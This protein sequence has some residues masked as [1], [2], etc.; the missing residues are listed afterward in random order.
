MRGH[1]TKFGRK[2]DKVLPH[3]SRTE[4]TRRPPG[5]AP[6]RRA[7]AS[8]STPATMNDPNHTCTQRGDHDHQPPQLSPGGDGHAEDTDGDDR[9]LKPVRVPHSNLLRI[10]HSRN[11]R[12]CYGAQRH[13]IPVIRPHIENRRSEGCGI[14]H[15]PR[16]RTTSIENGRSNLPTI[17][18]WVSL[19]NFRPFYLYVRFEEIRGN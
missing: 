3:C 10:H 15:F 17:G 2:K 11:S 6:P 5:P 4:T 1:G 16:R 14:R 12:R 19:G 9:P 18:N 13:R 8:S 7:S